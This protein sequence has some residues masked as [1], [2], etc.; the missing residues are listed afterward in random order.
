MPPPLLNFV[1]RGTKIASDDKK[2]PNVT[3]HEIF[4]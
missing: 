2:R 1:K 3:H 4:S